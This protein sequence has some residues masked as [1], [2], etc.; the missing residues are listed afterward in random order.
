L[1]SLSLFNYEERNILP[2]V[3]GRKAKWIGHILRTYYLLRHVIEGKIEGESE[4]M[5]RRGRRS[6]QLL[7]GVKESKLS[8]KLKEEALDLTLREPGQKL[9]DFSKERLGRDSAQGRREARKSFSHRE[10]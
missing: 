3:K 7:D 6:T 9:R 4:V 5:G 1:I 2:T 10:I 8:G